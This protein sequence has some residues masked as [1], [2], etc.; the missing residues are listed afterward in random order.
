MLGLLID[1]KEVKELEY[2]L[3]KEMEELLL[4]LGDKRIDCL[5]KRAME[6]R[7]Q[8]LFRIFK[9]FASPSDCTKYMRLL[10]QKTN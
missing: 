9:R 7:Y 3:K 5:V 6:E 10:R 4:D 8:L 1:F 2:L